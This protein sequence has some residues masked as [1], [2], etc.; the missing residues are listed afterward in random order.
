MNRQAKPSRRSYANGDG[1][2]FL[3]YG[4]QKGAESGILEEDVAEVIHEWRREC[5]EQSR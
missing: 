1:R 2:I 3:T 4:E 5:R